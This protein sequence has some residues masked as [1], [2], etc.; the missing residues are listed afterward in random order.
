MRP[1]ADGGR[2][3]QM[4]AAERVLTHLE[5]VL[6]IHL[7]WSVTLTRLEKTIDRTHLSVTT[8][9]VISTFVGIRR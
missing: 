7:Q 4:H 5:L 3:K 1:H 8:E 6:M 9:T 2:R